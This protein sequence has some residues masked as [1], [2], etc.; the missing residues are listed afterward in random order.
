VAGWFKAC[1]TEAA[2]ELLR[3]NHNA[4][5]LLYVIAARARWH[6]G[7]NVHNLAIGEAFVGDLDAIGLS[8]QQ[9]RTAKAVLAKHGFAT[10]KPTTKGT[11][12]KLANTAVF[13]ISLG[14]ANGQ[15]NAPPNGQPTDSQRLTKKEKKDKTGKRAAVKPTTPGSSEVPPPPDFKPVPS[16]AYRREIDTM[17]AEAEAQRARLK[18]DCRLTERVLRDCEAEQTA[19]LKAEGNEARARAI[20]EDPGSWTMKLN[21]AGK[22]HHK[23]WTERI[24]DLKAKRLTAT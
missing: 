7:F 13:D 18:D 12:A 20:H 19:K 3:A 5:V 1:R 22:Q 11:V 6:D 8:E 2:L 4:F 17:I 21:T 14:P 24:A 23:A 10:F 15:T 9:Y 16:N